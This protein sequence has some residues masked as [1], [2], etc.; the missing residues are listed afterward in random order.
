MTPGLSLLILAAEIESG[1]DLVSFQLSTNWQTNAFTSTPLSGFVPSRAV[2]TPFIKGHP[3]PASVL[4]ITLGVRA[5]ALRE[6]P[7]FK[8]IGVVRG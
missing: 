8:A 4:T 2:A 5:E 7:P 3:G 1:P 6:G